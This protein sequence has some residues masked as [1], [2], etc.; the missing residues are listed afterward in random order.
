MVGGVTIIGSQC[1]NQW[2][3]AGMAIVGNWYGHCW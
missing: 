1:G 2:M 3:V